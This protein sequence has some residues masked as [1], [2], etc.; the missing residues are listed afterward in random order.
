M[1][2]TKTTFLSTLAMIGVLASCHPA[3]AFTCDDPLAT[4]DQI[5]KCEEL[6][7][8]LRIDP[9]GEEK[10]LEVAEDLFPKRT[11]E[12]EDPCLLLAI[13]YDLC[14]E[15]IGK[16]WLK[17]QRE[18]GKIRCSHNVKPGTVVLTDPPTYNCD[19]LER[20]SAGEGRIRALEE[21]LQELERHIRNLRRARIK[22]NGKC[23]L[24]DEMTKNQQD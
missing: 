18:K 14:L 16:E 5:H 21:R 1:W 24:L 23:N 9:K 10:Q 22:E 3:V 15:T 6:E 2:S 12:G 4:Q 19:D 20:E 11:G 13:P 17:K 8:F 7:N